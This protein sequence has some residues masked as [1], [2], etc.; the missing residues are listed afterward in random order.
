MFRLTTA[1]MILA[2]GLSFNCNKEEEAVEENT[3]EVSASAGSGSNSKVKA[4]EDF[5]T[6]FCALTEKMKTASPADSV[7]LAKDF[8]SDSATFKTM[9]AD[10]EDIKAASDADQKAKVDA[11]TKKGTACAASAA[12]TKV[13]VPDIK[14]EIP[15]EIPKSV[16]TKLPGM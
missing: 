5:I 13:S 11:A 16:P 1:M 15:K 9:T 2:L 12:N 6:K 7:A 10:M 4:Y 8:A 14:K 3:E